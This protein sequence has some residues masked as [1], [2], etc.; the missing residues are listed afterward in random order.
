M[1]NHLDHRTE[2][3]RYLSQIMYGENEM[4]PS[5]DV[6]DAFVEFADKAKAYAF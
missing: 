2:S 3:G 4:L 5:D 6:V 1:V